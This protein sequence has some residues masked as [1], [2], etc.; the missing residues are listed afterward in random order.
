[1]KLV[2]MMGNKEIYFP[3]Q[4][5]K[6]LIRQIKQYLGIE[7]TGKTS[8]DAYLFI[9]EHLCDMTNA[10][11]EAWNRDNGESNEDLY[12]SIEIVD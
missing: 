4:H 8:Y 5:Q 11:V 6:R 9:Q 3:S 7:F 1:M 10:M 2:L 12:N